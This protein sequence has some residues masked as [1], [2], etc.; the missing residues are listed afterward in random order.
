MNEEKKENRFYNENK[1]LT[2]IGL[3]PE[4]TVGKNYTV[5]SETKDG[6]VKIINDDG[7]EKAFLKDNFVKAFLK[8]NFVLPQKDLLFENLEDEGDMVDNYQLKKE[9]N[10]ADVNPN[11]F[12]TNEFKGSLFTPNIL[13]N[14]SDLHE[15]ATVKDRGNAL[16]DD[17]FKCAAAIS[18]VFGGTDVDPDG[19]II[20]IRAHFPQHTID[21]KKS[22]YITIDGATTKINF[23]E[24]QESYYNLS[25]LTSK[26]T[27]KKIITKLIIRQIKKLF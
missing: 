14:A 13:L 24:I 23:K 21:R 6:Y 19:F 20:E 3:N 15:N 7:K 1:Q 10:I 25:K 27:A 11:D 8:D 12:A 17:T 26:S 16:L 4:L 22:N 5:I 18:N 9:K 2:F